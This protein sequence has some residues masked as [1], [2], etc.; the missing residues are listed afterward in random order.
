MAVA[1]HQAD[2]TSVIYRDTAVNRMVELMETS[3]DR[4]MDLADAVRL[5]PL[6]SVG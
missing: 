1:Y 6:P 5:L 2:V 4:P 3:R